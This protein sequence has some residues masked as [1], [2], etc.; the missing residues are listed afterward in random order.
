MD[1]SISK[2]SGAMTRYN[3]LE[4][5]GMARGALNKMAMCLALDDSGMKQR[6][7]SSDLERLGAE[8]RTVVH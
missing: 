2:Q 5:E 7:C 1:L 8:H 6:C 3:I 4:I